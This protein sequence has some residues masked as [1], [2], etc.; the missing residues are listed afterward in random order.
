MAA[1]PFPKPAGTALRISIHASLRR[2]SIYSSP[3]LIGSG[4]SRNNVLVVVAARGRPNAVVRCGNAEWE[5]G[6]ARLEEELFEFMES[7]QRPNHFPTKEDLLSA[8]RAD[9][10]H[11]IISHG[12]WLAAGWDSPPLHV[13]H[14]DADE[15]S[16][17]SDL[18]YDDDVDEEE[19]QDNGLIE[20]ERKPPALYAM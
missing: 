7:S 8:G 20:L 3:A 2:P 18:D 11:G 15:D 4:F 10:V 9:L 1:L 14:Y 5:H 16:S 13:G 6:N 19:I 17:E 12:G